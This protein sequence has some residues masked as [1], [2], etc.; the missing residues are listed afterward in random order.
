MVVAAAASSILSLYGS[1]AF[2]DA[3][4]GGAATDSPGVLSGNS[5]AVPVDVPVNACGNSVD[6]AAAL[7]PTFGNSC[8]NAPHVRHHHHR[9]PAMSYAEDADYG[10]GYGYDEESGRGHGDEPRYGYGDTPGHG[11]EGGYGEDDTPPP[12][13]TPPHGGHHTPPPSG[14][15]TPPP[16]TGGHH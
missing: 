7:N 1:P 2:A 3:Q 13:H 15:H 4:A 6:G 14:H 11:R 10:Y 16:P 5:V 8:V 12:H 9:V